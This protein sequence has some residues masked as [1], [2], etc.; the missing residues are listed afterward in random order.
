MAHGPWPM[1]GL[2]GN[3]GDG[4]V[5]GASAALQFCGNMQLPQHVR[6]KSTRKLLSSSIRCDSS[7]KNCRWA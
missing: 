2:A 5:A 1:A 4:G 7:G 6:G 3:N